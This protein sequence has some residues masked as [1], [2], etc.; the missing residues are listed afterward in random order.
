MNTLNGKV[1]LVCGGAT[2]IG[3]AVAAACHAAGAQV[4]VADFNDENGMTAAKESGGRFLHVDVT[5]EASLGLLRQGLEE[6][7]DHLDVLIHTAGVLEGAYED[8]EQF[9]PETFRHVWDVN[10]TGTFLTVKALLP[11]LRKSEKPVVILTSSGAATG[12]SS[13]YAYGSS[14]GGVNSFAI[15]LTRN[16]EAEGV[17]VNVVSPG[18]INTPMKRSVIHNETRKFGVEM[19]E[20]M[21]RADLGTPEGIAKVFLFLASDDADYVRGWITTR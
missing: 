14:K 13:S 17:R 5:D 4:Y 15:T 20:A 1:V 16:L 6:N 8:L 2:G 21:R 9:S 3:R 19:S 11:L 7:T 10:V 12:G 18:N